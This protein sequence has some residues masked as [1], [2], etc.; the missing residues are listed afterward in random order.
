MSALAASPASFIDPRTRAP[1]YGAYAGPLPPIVGSGV[2]WRDRLARRK[3]WVYLAV[4]SDDVWAAAAVVRMGYASN[5]FAF[6]YDLRD[7]TMLADE[8]ALAP[9]IAA[10]VADDPHADGEV[11]AFFFART[12]LTMSRRGETIAVEGRIGKIALDVRLDEAVAPPA[13]S[14]IAPLASG[15]SSLEPTLWDAT[16]KRALARVTGSATCAGRRVSLDGARGGY[17]YTHGLMPRHTRWR[18]AFA[19]GE[20][21]GAPFAFNVVQGFVGQPECAAFTKDGVHPLA[22]PRFVFDATEPLRPWRLEGDGID[23]AFVPGAMH[24]QYTNLGVV[25]SRFV[26]PVGTFRGT[27]RVDGRDV[28]LEGVPGVVEDQDVLW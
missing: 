13:V 6:V 3:R 22:E 18:W 9:S 20:A 11:A 2:G 21:G 5:A 19:L 26:Q 4:A 1:A 12:R 27:V 23:L 14:A 7:K 15:S 28:R 25:R 17:D 8:T 10:R 16:E 24:A